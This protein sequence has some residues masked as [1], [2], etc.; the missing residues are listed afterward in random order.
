MTPQPATETHAERASGFWSDI[1][2]VP[3]V[4][5]ISRILITIASAGLYLQGYRALGLIIGAVAGITDILDGWIAR[6]LNQSTELGA[7]LDRLSDLLT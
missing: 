3:N 2:T 5:S 7:I 4:M 6:K 1:R